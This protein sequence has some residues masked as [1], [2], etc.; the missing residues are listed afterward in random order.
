MKTLM[1]STSILLMALPVSGTLGA[2]AAPADPSKAARTARE[3]AAYATCA[4]CHGQDGKGLPTQPPM[5]PSLV[6]SKLA[7]AS[8]EV[9]ITIVLK[10]I[11]KADAKYLGVMAPLGSV[12]N[13]VQIADA[14]NYIRG[15]W[16]HQASAV[17]ADE[18]RAVREKYKE[19][20]ASLP[21]RAYEKKAVDLESKPNSQ[22]GA[23]R[24][25]SHPQP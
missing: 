13:D 21:R 23:P 12:M 22:D 14:L 15:S 4:A 7:T 6:G 24:T 18:V 10:G 9:P 16:G 20:N 8:P 11:Q 25:N 1:L 5:A 19:I 2:D 3:K 17:T